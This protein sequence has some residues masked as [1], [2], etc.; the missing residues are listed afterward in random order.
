ML[1]ID[2]RQTVLRVTACYGYVRGFEN[3]RRDMLTA[4]QQLAG[5][6]S[7][8]CSPVAR[9]ALQLGNGQFKVRIKVGSILQ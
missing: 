2:D 3:A 1:T 8:N 6:A 4:Q 5:Q 9:R 7:W